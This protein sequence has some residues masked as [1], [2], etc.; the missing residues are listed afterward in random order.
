MSA[1][2][3]DGGIGGGE[4]SELFILLLI[5]G[6]DFTNGMAVYRHVE[7]HPWR[8]SELRRSRGH[9][10]LPAKSAPNK[11][12]REVAGREPAEAPDRCRR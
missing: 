11:H 8:G 12:R 1:A 4:A 7:P 5:V 9:L 3:T 10:T 2:T 6:G